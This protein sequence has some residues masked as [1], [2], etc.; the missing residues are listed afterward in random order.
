MTIY[1]SNALRPVAGHTYIPD[2]M[3]AR[4]DPVPV[5][6]FPGVLNGEHLPVR[7][8]QFEVNWTIGKMTIDEMNWWKTL[9]GW[10]SGDP[11]SNIAK[12]F[13]MDAQ[14]LPA[15]RLW[16]NTG[17]MVNYKVAT[18]YMPQWSHYRNGFFHDCVV[19][20]S[21]LQEL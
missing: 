20:F 12:K 8:G 19:K 9:I 3:E 2:S 6:P 7:A 11:D 17:T 10:V 4:G 18:I 21:H 15:A 13:I 5:P 14:P 16:D 1:S